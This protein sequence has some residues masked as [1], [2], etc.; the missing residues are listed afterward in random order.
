MKIET[1]KFL[2]IM[3]LSL[4]AIKSCEIASELNKHN[5]FQSKNQYQKDQQ[6]ILS[7]RF[8]DKYKE[9]VNDCSKMLLDAYQKHR[10]I[11]RD[12]AGQETLWE[13]LKGVHDAEHYIKQH[14]ELRHSYWLAN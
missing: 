13:Y 6:S 7:H 5:Q 1:F 10:E 2:V 14:C 9:A 8:Y 3:L 12:Q 11:K 4:I